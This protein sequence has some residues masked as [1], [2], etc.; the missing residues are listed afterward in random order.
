MGI[1][2]SRQ[3]SLNRHEEE[4]ARLKKELAKKRELHESLSQSLL[5]CTQNKRGSADKGIIQRKCESIQNQINEV[6]TD[7]RTLDKRISR[8]KHQVNRM[9]SVL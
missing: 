5:N 2:D 7:I 1:S 8:L 9:K 6:L 4:I 3:K